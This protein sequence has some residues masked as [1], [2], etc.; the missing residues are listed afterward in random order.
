[1]NIKFSL[2]LMQRLIR[3]AHPDANV[4]DSSPESRKSQRLNTSAS[5]LVRNTL[6]GRTSA[7]RLSISEQGS[8]L[9]SVEKLTPIKRNLQQEIN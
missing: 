4:T 9:E 1:M 8:V 7:G 5:Q 6:Q 3:D 2:K